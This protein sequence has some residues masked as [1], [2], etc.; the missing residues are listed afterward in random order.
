[1]RSRLTNQRIVLSGKNIKN[2]FYNNDQ[3]DN[4]F[5]SLYTP[6]YFQFSI[7]SRQTE[8]LWKHVITP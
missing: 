8:L 4:F 1:M 7:K 2:R 3:Q 6:D 5:K